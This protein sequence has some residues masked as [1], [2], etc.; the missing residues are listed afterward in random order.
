MH[1]YGKTYFRLRVS[2]E[3]LLIIL[4]SCAFF[5]IRM[6]QP[7]F[8]NDNAIITYMLMLA[9][10]F[11]RN[12]GFSFRVGISQKMRPLWWLLAGVLLSFIPAYLFYGQH[13]YYSVVAYRHFLGYFAFFALLSVQPRREELKMALYAFTVIY[14]ICTLYVSFVNPKFIV[15]EAKEG[16]EF[17]E[18]GD[19]VHMLRG[20]QF[21][22]L[23]YI[24]ALDDL[25]KEKI[26]FKNSLMAV[27]VFLVIFMI[28]N[29]SIL[30]SC[31][32]L[33]IFAALANKSARRR[34]IT[35]S[36]MLVLLA[37][38]VF[39]MFQ[40]IDKLFTETIEQLSDQDY[41][42]VKA[43]VYFTSGENGFLSILLGNGFISGKVNPIMENL[44]LDGIYHSDLGL[45]G[46]WHQFGLIP[47]LTILV[48]CFRALSSMHEFLVRANALNILLCALT[49]AYFREFSYSLWLCLFWFL[50]ETDTEYMISRRKRYEEQ[51]RAAMR[52]FRSISSS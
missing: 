38:A 23:A 15:F 12:M 20:I 26:G 32:V 7:L 29:R 33:T 1:L 10:F 42:R 43:F 41:N 6:F 27:F 24:F 47:V 18:E 13:L 22:P 36:F 21:L 39:F 50:F 35:G 28:Q 52:R 9:Y 34:L 45:I 30:F 8:R 44:R 16:L 2:F 49:I 25:R 46:F 17:I 11:I 4:M 40:Y 51:V 19:F 14:F 5:D 37:L 3:I 31:I 48:V